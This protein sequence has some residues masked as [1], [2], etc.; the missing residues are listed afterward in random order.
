VGMFATLRPKFILVR[1]LQRQSL[2]ASIYVAEFEENLLD[3]LKESLL[4]IGLTAHSAI[5]HD[6]RRVG[7][8]T[9]PVGST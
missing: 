7:N 4:F 1:N 5:K 9:I 6:C 8:R 3:Y 2:D